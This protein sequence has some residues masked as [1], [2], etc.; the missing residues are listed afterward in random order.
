MRLPGQG[1]MADVA[2][3]HQNFLMYLTRHSPLSL[4]HEV[5]IVS[6]GRGLASPEERR[7]AGLHPGE[8]RLVTNLGSFCQNP[9]TRLLELESLHPGVSREH[10][11]EQTGFEIILADGFQESPPPTA[12]E[13][14]VL[15]TEIDPLGIRRLEFIPSKERTA[16]IDELLR[17]EEGFIAEET[18]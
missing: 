12:E 9:E 18:R 15:R 17:L 14:R 6:A 10:L 1:G 11:R 3:L 4:V 8:V 16:L 7:A 5:E 13:L 2:N